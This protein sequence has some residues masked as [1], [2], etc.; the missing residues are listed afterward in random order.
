[1]MILQYSTRQ[2][3]AKAFL[4]Y[5]L[6][7]AGQEKVAEA[8]LI[9]ARSDITGQRPGIDDLALIEVDKKAMG[10]R[11]GDILRQFRQIMGL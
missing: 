10:A 9:P 7:E 6:S 1:M 5:V 4:D 11:R 8:Y 2:T 3:H